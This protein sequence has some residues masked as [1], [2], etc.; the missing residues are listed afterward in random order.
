LTQQ[1]SEFEIYRDILEAVKFSD[2]KTSIM[3][4]AN[5]DFDEFKCYMSFL[6]DN[7]FIRSFVDSDKKRWII[8]EKGRDLLKNLE[9]FLRGLI[10]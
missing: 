10:D 2:I 6:K 1:R 9:G 8:T 3:R 4:K 5:L 7:E